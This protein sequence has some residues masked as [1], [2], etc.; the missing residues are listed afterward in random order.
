MAIVPAARPITFILTN[1]RARAEAFYGDVLELPE[2]SLD[3]FA[4]VYDLGAGAIMRLTPCRGWEPHE[5]TVM[6]W[7]IPDIGATM[8]E[9]RGKGMEFLIFDGTGQDDE[10]LWES[11]DGAI[12][13]AWFQDPDGNV[14]SLTQ[15]A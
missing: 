3:E 8:A 9:L 12:R 15:V 13:A 10:G 14:L 2:L 1:D 4:T 5:H 11:D 7:T 6:G